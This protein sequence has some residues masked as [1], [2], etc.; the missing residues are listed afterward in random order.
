MNAT[1]IFWPLLIQVWITFYAYIL[2]ARRKSAAL[3]QGDVDLERR[4]LHED[5]WPDSVLQVNNH[6]RNSFELPTLFYALVLS[7]YALNAVD[8]LALALAI[9]FVLTRVIHA[10]VHLGRN[11]V[12]IR[13]PVFMAGA[14][15]LL[16][17]SGLVARALLQ[18]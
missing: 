9:A 11:T 18:S 10:Y 1:L 3:R 4:A 13:R 17:M 6:I 7:L 12:A 2:L 8:M 15:I 5:A 16:T 14:F